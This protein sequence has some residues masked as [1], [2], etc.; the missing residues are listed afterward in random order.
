[1]GPG[2][3]RCQADSGDPETLPAPER[4]PPMPAVIEVRHLHKRYGANVAVDDVSFAVQQGEIFG[5]T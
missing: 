4:T 5:I 1:M 3:P 2:H